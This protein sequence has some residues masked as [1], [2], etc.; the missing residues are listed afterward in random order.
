MGKPTTGRGGVLAK[1][2]HKSQLLFL[3]ANLNIHSSIAL[4]FVKVILV[5]LEVGV[6]IA[7]V[8]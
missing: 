1:F 7:C 6:R 2:L 4:H 3:Q 8:I 5:S